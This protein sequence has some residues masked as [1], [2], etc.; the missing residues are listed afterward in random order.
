MYT[1][2]KVQDF[3]QKTTQL[4]Q[5]SRVVMEVNRFTTLV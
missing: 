2:G 4:C 3:L 5:I 1:N